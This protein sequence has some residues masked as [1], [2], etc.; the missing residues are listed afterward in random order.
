[1]S[2][3]DNFIRV[4]PEAVR[5]RYFPTDPDNSFFYRIVNNEVIMSRSFWTTAKII[6]QN[7]WTPFI[8]NTSS[9]VRKAINMK[10]INDSSEILPLLQPSSKSSRSRAHSSNSSF[11]KDF[12]NAKSTSNFNVKPYTEIKPVEK[13]LITKRHSIT[14]MLVSEWID[15]SSFLEISTGD[16]VDYLSSTSSPLALD[17]GN[18]AAIFN[19]AVMDEDDRMLRMRHKMKTLQQTMPHALGPLKIDF[20]NVQ[21]E[22]EPAY[23]PS[24]LKEEI[25]GSLS[26]SLSHEN[27]ILHNVNNGLRDPNCMISLPPIFNH[28]I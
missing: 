27:K 26:L 18:Q 13:V 2:I 9:N 22:K 8:M 23:L 7:Q 11:G 4:L 17:S 14:D 6:E 24:P 15:P 16:P 12:N 25:N 10:I 5:L 28:I 1:M 3:N 21:M 20:I 19:M